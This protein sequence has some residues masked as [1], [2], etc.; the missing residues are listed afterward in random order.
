MLKRA[1]QSLMAFHVQAAMHSLTLLARKPLATM[2]TVI[3]LAI[4][5]ALPALFWVFADNLANLTLSWQKNGYISLYL[6]SN[7][8]PAE[9]KAFISRLEGIVGVGQARLISPE[10]GLALLSSQEGMH[11]MMQYLPENPLPALIEVTPALTVDSQFKLDQLFQTLKSQPE[12]E[13]A[14]L[15]MEWIKRL[16]M[17]MGF[18]HQLARALLILLALAVVLIIGNTLRL[19]IQNRQE[20]IQVLKLIGAPDPFIV[21]PYLYSGLWYGL[22]GAVVAILLV[23]IFLLSLAAVLEALASVYQMHYPL[24]GMSLNQMLLLTA[25]AVL[26]GWL[27]ARLSVYRQMASIEPY[28]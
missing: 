1:Y 12:V 18:A 13:L 4:S 3:V 19:S 8:S 26:L 6:R 14:K 23:N 15:D 9:Q 21:R 7:V 16:Q 20:E 17:I 10:E 22:A 11:D 25:F 27:G 2:M 24:R 28:K 5:L